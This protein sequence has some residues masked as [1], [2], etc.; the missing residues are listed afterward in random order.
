[1]LVATNRPSGDSL[2]RRIPPDGIPSGEV[3]AGTTDD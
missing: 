2:Y 1:M 3:S